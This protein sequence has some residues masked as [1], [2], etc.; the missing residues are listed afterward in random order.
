MAYLSTPL[1]WE[2][3]FN[4]EE[5]DNETRPELRQTFLNVLLMSQQHQPSDS[6]TTDACHFKRFKIQKY[7]Q[8]YGKAV[9][10]M[11]LLN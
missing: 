6:L 3:V 1:F 2:W 10:Y 11:L 9:A 8:T 4:L 5:S 7:A